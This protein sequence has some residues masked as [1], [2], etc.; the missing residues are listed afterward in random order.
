MSGAKI[1]AGVI[2]SCQATANRCLDF[3]AQQLRNRLL[4]PL[5]NPL[6]NKAIDTM[7]TQSRWMRRPVHFNAGVTLVLQQHF[8]QARALV[9]L[10]YDR[11]IDLWSGENGSLA[12]A[13]YRSGQC[14]RGHGNEMNILARGVPCAVIRRA[15]L[16]LR[17]SCPFL[18]PRW[19]S[20]LAK[21]GCMQAQTTHSVRV[22]LLVSD[23]DDTLSEGDT[24]STIFEAAADA[25]ERRGGTAILCIA[26]IMVQYL[27][28]Q[29]SLE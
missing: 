1:L 12:T 25:A 6:S 7:R 8:S 20:G 26:K 19:S 21:P 28:C 13:A 14:M 29:S 11:K 18:S 24:I 23:F 2:E 4:F 15:S 5:F 10:V 27:P 17:S 16:D 22:K 3:P 9:Q